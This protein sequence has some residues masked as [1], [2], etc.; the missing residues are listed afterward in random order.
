S[1][2]R[3]LSATG[4]HAELNGNV[5]KALAAYLDTLRLGVRFAR[6]GLYIHGLVGVAIKGIGVA[7]VF[8]IRDQLSAD[9]CRAAIAAISEMMKQQEP[10]EAFEYRDLLWTQHA[11][12]WH[13]RL[14][15]VLSELAG[16]AEPGRYRS[17]FDRL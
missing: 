15:S 8:R 17:G 4:K 6:G 5:D 13:G 12:G 2:A 14:Y 11:T 9:Q 1:L 10:Y 7:R 16:E 3:G